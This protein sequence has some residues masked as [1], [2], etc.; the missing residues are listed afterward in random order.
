M[1]I[2]TA[3]IDDFSK[4]KT[5]YKEVAKHHGG[6]ARLEYEITDDYV[7]NF[8]KKSLATGLIIVAENP[9]DPE[10]LIAEIHAYK[11]GI[12]VFNHVLGDLTLVVHPAFQGKKLGRTIFTIFL[13]EIGR[14]RP[15]IGKVELIARESNLKAI[16]LYESLGFSIEG[17]LEMRIK[18]PE[19]NYEADI[20]MGWQNPN[21][22]F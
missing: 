9:E 8:L 21:F 16:A 6:I 20:P 10:Q 19:G 3:D 11:S 12:N 2:R 17:R 15:D 4:I 22:E 14:N 5:L 18:T 13:E 7:E 1:H